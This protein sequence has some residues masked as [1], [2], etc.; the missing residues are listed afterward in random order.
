MKFRVIA[1]AHPPDYVG[2]FTEI[3]TWLKPELYIKLKRYLS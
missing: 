3:T 1:G 2:L